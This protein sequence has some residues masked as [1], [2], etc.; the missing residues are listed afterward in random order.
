MPLPS[1]LNISMLFFAEE[2]RTADRGEPGDA[3]DPGKL[4]LV[5][6]LYLPFDYG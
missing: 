6:L 3:E 2:R 4:N 1:E 5:D